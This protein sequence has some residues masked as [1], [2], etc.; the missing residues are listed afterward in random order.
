M[1]RPIKG[2]TPQAEGL[3]QQAA[4]PGNVRELRNVIEMLCLLRPGK[5][6]R[7]RDLPPLVQGSRE[8][9]GELATSLTLDLALPLEAMIERILEAVVAAEGGNRT[10]A[11]HRL[12][13][14]VRTL[15]RHALQASKKHVARP[16]RRA[17][18]SS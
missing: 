2:I 4:W 3:L 17:K 10:R 13:I 15:Q 9:R 1:N 5:I 12:G 7:R 6:V 16:G 18:K 14:S 11:A 8:S